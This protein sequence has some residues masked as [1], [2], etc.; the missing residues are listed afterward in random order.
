M[1]SRNTALAEMLTGNSA[2]A[3][4]DTLESLWAKAETFGHVGIFS[5][6]SSARQKS[7]Q[8]RITFPTI[9]GTQLEATSKFDLTLT[10]ALCQAIAKAELIRGQF[11]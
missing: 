6:T 5:S 10:E 2:T 11:K 8:A 3:S 9:D 1:T 4:T 7:Y